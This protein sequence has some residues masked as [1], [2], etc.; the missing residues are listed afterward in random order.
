MEP[1]I[2]ICLASAL[3]LS[4][5]GCGDSSAPPAG[6]PTSDGMTTLPSGLKYRIVKDG[7]GSSPLAKD[8]VEVHYRGQFGDGK[9]F[10]SSYSRGQP[11]VFPVGRVIKGWTEA[12]QLMKEGAKWQLCIPPELAYG[13]NGMPPVIPPEATLYFEVELLKVRGSR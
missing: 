7:T 8:E 5:A 6:K 11:A 13:K 4:V 12:L 10:D 2:V 9:E 3:C 1:L